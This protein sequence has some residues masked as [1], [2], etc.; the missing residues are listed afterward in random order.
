MLLKVDAG[1]GSDFD[2]TGIS[3]KRLRYYLVRKQETI[4]GLI[5]APENLAEAAA[6]LST[7]ALTLN[8]ENAN[9]S[10]LGGIGITFPALFYTFNP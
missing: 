10:N 4:A 7:T 9:I 8:I 5:D 6:R 2:R 3:T 1:K